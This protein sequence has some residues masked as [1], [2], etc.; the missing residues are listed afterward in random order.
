MVS[1]LHQQGQGRKEAGVMNTMGAD[2]SVPSPGWTR[3]RKDG[4]EKRR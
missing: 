4:Q 3:H 2:L 1:G